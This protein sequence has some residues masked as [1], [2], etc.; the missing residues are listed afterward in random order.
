M[1][2]KPRLVI[3]RRLPPSVEA[4]A[5]S[6]FEV[7]SN[8]EDSVLTPDQIIERVE[9]HRAD[10]LLVCLTDRMDAALIGRLPAGLRIIV[11]YSVGTNHLDLA[12]ARQRGI[13]LAYTPDATTEATADL[14]M[15]LL[16]SACRRAHEHQ[17]ILRSGGWG[18]WNAWDKLGTD[19]GGKVL[20]LVGM[21]RIGRAVAK[22]AKGFGMT[23]AYHQ[24][25]RLSPDLEDGAVFHPTLEALFRASRIVSLHTPS[26][27][28]TMGQINR[29]SL[30]WLPD[31]AILINT[32]RGDQVVDD[33][34]IEALRQG[35]LAAAGLDV[36]TGEPDFDRRYLELPNATLL[37]HIGTSTV[38]TRDQ[39]GFDAIAN[40][41]DFFSGRQPRWS[42]A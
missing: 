14:A 12:A 8:P 10:A 18:A 9:R 41:D 40:L 37:P 27:P 20:G 2:A 32:A 4:R 13:T 31:G 29:R 1:T 36:F 33:D 19:P 17:A 25:N 34:L 11:T 28:E 15:L 26:T 38:E 30:S 7:L 39:M 42:V 35:R 6:L 16:L 21:G 3:T 23:I 5:A 24:R 22:R